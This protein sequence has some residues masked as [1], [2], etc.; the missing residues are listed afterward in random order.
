MRF[1]VQEQIRGSAAGRGPRVTAPGRQASHNEFLRNDTNCGELVKVASEGSRHAFLQRNVSRKPIRSTTL[2][3]VTHAGEVRCT[4][5]GKWVEHVALSHA[6]SNGASRYL[7]E[8]YQSY[9]F[10]KSVSGAVY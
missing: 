3:I 9:R 6:P 2:K 10:P 1:V 7:T 4:F 5:A 8:K